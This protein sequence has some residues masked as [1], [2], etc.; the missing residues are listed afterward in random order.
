MPLACAPL[1][2]C[3]YLSQSET[4]LSHTLKA[5]L[6]R[7]S[8]RA[9]DNESLQCH[10]GAIIVRDLS[11]IVSNYRS[12]QSLDEFCKAQGVMGIADI[13]T[14]QLTRL[15][16]DTGC[17]NGA[18]STDASK[19]DDELADLARSFDI[20]GRDLLSVVTGTTN[21]AWQFKTDEEWEF[22]PLSVSKDR[23]K[24]RPVGH[25]P[26]AARGQLASLRLHACTMRA[27]M[28]LCLRSAGRM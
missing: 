27:G 12:N 3:W 2:L 1:L 10:L 13:D 22:N 28:P 19:S 4:L 6:K 11:C 20:L 7:G 5:H 17:L 16:R 8:A 24:V 9:E 18:I 26:E 25:A 14:R 23:Y 15:L 21:G